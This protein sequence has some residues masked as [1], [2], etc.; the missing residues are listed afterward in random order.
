MC[1]S[2]LRIDSGCGRLCESFS[3]R[4]QPAEYNFNSSNELFFGDDSIDDDSVLIGEVGFDV[5]SVIVAGRVLSLLCVVK[6]FDRILSSWHRFTAEFDCVVWEP[7][8][9]IKFILLFPPGGFVI[10]EIKETKITPLG[11]CS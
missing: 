7:S 2:L 4:P 1:D 9:N 5:C 10:L 3:G 6:I 11:M 8:P